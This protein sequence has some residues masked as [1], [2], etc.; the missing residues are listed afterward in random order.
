LPPYVKDLFVGPP[1][2]CGARNLLAVAVALIS[3]GLSVS[4]G[5]ADPLGVPGQ[6]L[7]DGLAANTKLSV[8]QGGGADQ[9]GLLSKIKGPAAMLDF[10]RGALGKS[11]IIAGAMDGS[12]QGRGYV[13][14]TSQLALLPGTQLNFNYAGDERGGLA[15][16]TRLSQA[17]GAIR[18]IWSDTLN[19]GFESDWTGSGATRASHMNEGWLHWSPSA[20]TYGIGFRETAHADGSRS[21]DLRTLEMTPLGGGTL[22]D[23]TVIRR[24]GHTSG[25]LIYCGSLNSF[26]L[27]GEIDSSDLRPKMALLD[28]EKSIDQSWSLYLVAGQSLD[29]KQGNIDVGASREIGGFNA[30]FYGGATESGSAYVGLRFS[31]ALSPAARQERW[32]G[33][34]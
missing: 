18:L 24:D 33:L 25:S 28:I 10:D 15:A 21:T 13:A 26:Q 2:G 6:F 17:L 34:H 29:A 9:K 7:S 3:F 23:S 11:E 30:S 5:L 1:G 14:G 22:I 4:V 8:R 27:T 20:T 32:V 16:E 31:L 19:R 12:G